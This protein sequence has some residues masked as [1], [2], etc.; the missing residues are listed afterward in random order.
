MLKKIKRALECANKHDRCCEKV[1]KFPYSCKKCDND[2]NLNEYEKSIE[3]A[4]KSLRSLDIILEKLNY[5]SN[6]FH[7]EIKIGLDMAINIIYKQ[8]ESLD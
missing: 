8:L 3:L 6:V 4:F 7:D 5:E 2:W 1:C